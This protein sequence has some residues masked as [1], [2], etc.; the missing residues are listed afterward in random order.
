M[1]LKGSCHCRATQF[2][3]TE[4]PT[5]VTSCNC[6]LCGK[7]G[8]LH[9]YYDVHQFKLTTV[10]D[11][12]STYQFGHYVGQH[13]HCA[14][15]GCGTYSEFPDFSTGEPNYERMKVSV[16]ARLFD[17]EAFDV[18]AVPVKRVNGRTDW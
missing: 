11:R 12:V 4:P 10:R 15:C 7:R 8:Q 14:I 13:H 6:S 17:V 3:V 5:E 2:E 9:A 16:N 18:D 1:P